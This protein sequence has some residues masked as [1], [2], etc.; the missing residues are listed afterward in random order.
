MH[1]L[2]TS[3][4]L[5]MQKKKSSTHYCLYREP[6]QNSHCTDANT[7]TYENNILILHRKP[8]LC[9]QH[10]A[11]NANTKLAHIL[12]SKKTYSK[13]TSIVLGF[14]YIPECSNNTCIQQH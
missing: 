1:K 3:T 5:E 11:T 6:K 8:K 12:I 10:R 9:N 2:I 14:S 4:Q 13:N 7:S